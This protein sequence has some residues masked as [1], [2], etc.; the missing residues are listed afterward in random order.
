MPEVIFEKDS[1]FIKKIQK[2]SQL[3]EWLKEPIVNWFLN[4]LRG[5]MPE[6]KSF[7]SCMIVI[8]VTPKYLCYLPPRQMVG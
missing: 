7:I 4:K 5:L 6:N 8:S 3:N 1:A 2:I